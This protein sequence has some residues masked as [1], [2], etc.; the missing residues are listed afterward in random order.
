MWEDDHGLVNQQRRQ[1]EIKESK[2]LDLVSEDLL[3]AD[4]YK[5]VTQTD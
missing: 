3:L 4:W 2:A 5:E 1:R